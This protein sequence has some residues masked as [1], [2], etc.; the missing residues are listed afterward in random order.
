[1]RGVEDGELSAQRCQP[2]LNP[3]SGPP[4][5]THSWHS[6]TKMADKTRLVMNNWWT[7]GWPDGTPTVRN[8]ART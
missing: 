1:M 7:I 8:T 4:K 6:L 3:R 5:P 2:L